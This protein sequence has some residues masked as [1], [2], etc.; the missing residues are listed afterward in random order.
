MELL[1]KNAIPDPN[2]GENERLIQWVGEVDW[3]YACSFETVSDVVGKEHVELFFEGLDTFATVTLNGK[4]ILRSDNM[5]IPARVSV[6]DVLK[7]AGEANELSIVFDSVLRR[8]LELEKKYGERKSMMRD[9]RRMHIRKAQYH[10]G[11]DW[12]PIVLTAGPYMPIHLESYNSRIDNTHIVSTLNDNLTSADISIAVN[13]SHPVEGGAARF[14]VLDSSGVEAGSASLDLANE[15]SGIARVA[16]NTPKLWWPNGQGDQHLYTVKASL[17][18][19]SGAVLDEKSE[20][21]GVRSIELI[22]R[23]LKEAKGTTFMFRINQRDIFTQG[24]DWIPAD[25]LLPAITRERYFD[26]VKIA[27]H[28]H[29]NMIRVWGGGIYETEDFFDACDEFG[30]LVWHDY[31]FACGDYP[32]HDEFMKS[33][34]EEMEA[35]TIRLRNRT[36]LALLCGGNEDFMLADWD[37]KKY[38]HSDL[39]GPF[40]GTEFPQRKIYLDLLPKL[41]TKLCPNVI[42]WA[43]SPFG[44][45]EEHNDRTVGDIHQWS[46]W[47]LEQLP[48]QE[49][50]NIGGRFVSEFGMH[51]F[52]VQRTVDYFCQGASQ[53]QRHPQSRLIDCHNKGHGAHTRIA[54]YLAENFRFDMTSLRNFVYSSQLLQSEALGYALQQWKRQFR[55]PGYEECA[56]A[57]IWQLNDVYPSTSWAYVDFFLRPKPSYYTIRRAFA[58]VSVGV[59]REPSARWVDEDRPRISEVPS[60]E[61]WAHNTTPEHIE[62]LLQLKAYDFALGKWTDLPA[63]QKEQNVSLKPGQT[64]ELTTLPSHESWSNDSLILL[65]ATLIGPN[66]KKLARYVDWPEPYRYLYWPE[67]TKLSITEQAIL[68]D[69]EGYDTLV[70]VSATE[71]LKGVWLEAVCGVSDKDQDSDPLWEDNML[72]LMPKQDIQ[73]RVKGLKGRSVSA[74]FLCDWELPSGVAQ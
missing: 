34:A 47:H 60:F 55:G 46:V 20:K 35:Q 61:I 24:G 59:S 48:Y 45:K 74:R 14:T 13:L 67:S 5:F 65:E 27:A 18:D 42:Y 52:P 4:I 32:T 30:I 25:M 16:L 43:N 3:E 50:K 33:L 44:G 11:W 69:A 41:T 53:A 62:A 71:P 51:G 64:T 21:F 70:T 23:P 9:K 8:G 6:K 28:A 66:G 73:V 68:G 39:E 17:T 1:Q 22:Q 38:D 26:W 72:D 12:G 54:R 49:Y 56:G 31:A 7:P 19:S 15:K 63:S 58:P 37:K 2:V 57:L 40:D 36:S 10:W 29:H